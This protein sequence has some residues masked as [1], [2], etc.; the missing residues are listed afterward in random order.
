MAENKKGF[1]LYADMIY[2]IEKLPD[3][4][5]GKLIKIIFD[6]V[7]DKNPIIDDLLL[8]IA[9]EPIKLQL[10]RDLKEWESKCNKHSESGRLGGIKSGETRRSKKQNEANEAQL[11][12]SKQNEA[13]EADKETVKDKEKVIVKETVINNN[14]DFDFCEIKFLPLLKTWIDYKKIKFNE[15]LIQMQIES[16]YKQ[17]I[18][19]SKNN[20][21]NAEKIVNQSISASSKSIYELKQ[22][23]QNGKNERSSQTAKQS[24]GY[25]KL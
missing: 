1:I 20:F 18:D 3:D 23:Q 21:L 8:Q 22:Q 9:F 16:F 10:K 4:I 12:K 14:F 5:A 13:N 6:Y 24:G 2:V 11:K 19:L 17:L 25:G 7:N 15:S